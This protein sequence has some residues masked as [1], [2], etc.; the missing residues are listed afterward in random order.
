[1][2]VA[3]VIYWIAVTAWL[4]SAGVLTANCRNYQASPLTFNGLGSF[5]NSSTYTNSTA[6][7]TFECY[8][9]VTST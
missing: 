9:N 5:Y 4:Y 2:Q 8:T 7:G 1:M 6:S 3:L